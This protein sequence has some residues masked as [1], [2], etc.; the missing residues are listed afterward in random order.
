MNENGKDLPEGTRVWTWLILCDDGTVIS[1][2]ENPFPKQHVLDDCQKEIVNVVRRNI[3]FIVSGVSKEHANTSESESLVTIRVRNF[4]GTEQDQA[5]IQQEDSPSLIFYYIFDDWVSSYGLI[6]KRQH[7]YGVS[8]E[9][10]VNIY[11][12]FHPWI[13]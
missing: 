2:Q 8:L 4:H 3:R 13:S 9:N 10:L 1:I 11:I 7:Q 6:A 12:C 5:S